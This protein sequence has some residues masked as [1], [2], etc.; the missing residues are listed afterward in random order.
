MFI[1]R[2]AN[3]RFSSVG[4]ASVANRFRSYGAG[5]LLA[6]NIYKHCAPTERE[7]LCKYLWLPACRGV[8]VIPMIRAETADK[9]AAC[10]TL[11][12]NE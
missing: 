5:R 8:V 4:A 11:S 1:E 3:V 6:V 12:E 9:L 2:I 7:K 10:R